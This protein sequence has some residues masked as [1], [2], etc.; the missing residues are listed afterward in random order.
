MNDANQH[1]PHDELD[2]TKPIN[3][4]HHLNPPKRKNADIRPHLPPPPPNVNVRQPVEQ[5]LY[6]G[7]KET[8]LDKALKLSL[9]VSVFVSLFV[10]V[11]PFIVILIICFSCWQMVANLLY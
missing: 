6:V 1:N 8:R 2:D 4:Y 7:H 3:V 5:V 11:L 10:A 9:I